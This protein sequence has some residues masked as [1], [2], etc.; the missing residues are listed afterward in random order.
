[1]QSIT[2][3]HS[4]LRK[5]KMKNK[6][7]KIIALI[8]IFLSCQKEKRTI[9]PELCGTRKLDSLTGENVSH[10][11]GAGYQ[12]VRRKLTEPEIIFLELKEN[13]DYKITRNNI[14]EEKGFIKW[15][16]IAK[17][18]EGKILDEVYSSI[19]NTI[20]I[21]TYPNKAFLKKTIF[22]KGDFFDPPKLSFGLIDIVRNQSDTIYKTLRVSP[23]DN[24]SNLKYYGTRIK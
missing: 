16:I 14:E 11:Q 10:S 19:N 2:K 6:F 13:G 18:R 20:Y 9:I 1:M 17:L 23:S 12:N 21:N 7:S 15:E 22:K 4:N 5:I 24:D 8:F 3:R